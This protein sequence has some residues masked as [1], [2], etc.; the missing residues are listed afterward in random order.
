VTC[1][2][3]IPVRF[4]NT[5]LQPARTRAV[6]GASIYFEALPLWIDSNQSSAVGVGN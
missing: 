5:E 1:Q 2:Q 6:R 4:V 3:T